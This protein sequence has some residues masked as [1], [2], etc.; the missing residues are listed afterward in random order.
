MLSRSP[1]HLRC[2]AAQP[3]RPAQVI[4]DIEV[5]MTIYAHISLDDKRNALGRLGG[6]LG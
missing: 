4:R 5:T 1:A 3:R 2:P 6:A